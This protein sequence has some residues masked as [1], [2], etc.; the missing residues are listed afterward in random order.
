LLDKVADQ[1]DS[2]LM[3]SVKERFPNIPDLK[4]SDLKMDRGWLQ[5]VWR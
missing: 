5:A 2:P 4:L 3:G 1:K